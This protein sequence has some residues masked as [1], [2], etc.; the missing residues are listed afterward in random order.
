MQNVMVPATLH[1]FGDQHGDLL[2]RILPLRFQNILHNRRKD[3]DPIVGLGQFP[4]ENR[5]HNLIRGLPRNWRAAI[6]AMRGG[7]ET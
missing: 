1:Q 4:L 7:A 2:V 5:P 3:H 6:W